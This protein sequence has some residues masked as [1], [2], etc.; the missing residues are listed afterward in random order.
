MLAFSKNL[1]LQLPKHP[2][3]NKTALGPRTVHREDISKSVTQHIMQMVCSHSRLGH[4]QPGLLGPFLRVI[5][6]L[7]RLTPTCTTAKKFVV[8]PTATGVLPKQ[9]ERGVLWTETGVGHRSPVPPGFAPSFEFG[10]G[11]GPHKF[12]SSVPA[13]GPGRGQRSGSDHRHTHTTPASIGRL[14]AE[15]TT[16]SFKTGRVSKC[17]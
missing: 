6:T 4:T 16:P 12:F 11:G 17:G 15:S 2:Q 8:I 3:T 10:G 9:K 14:H 7:S 5:S 1:S 13:D